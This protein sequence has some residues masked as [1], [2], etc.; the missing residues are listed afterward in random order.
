MCKKQRDISCNG[1]VL[2]HGQ[3]I[4]VFKDIIFHH[5]LYGKRLV[6][7]VFFVKVLANK[8][9]DKEFYY[10]LNTLGMNWT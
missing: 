10:N 6:Q 7:Q 9:I 2:I 8:N 3:W 4:D 5:A 1:V